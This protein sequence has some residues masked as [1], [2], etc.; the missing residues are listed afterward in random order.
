[1]I[2]TNRSWRRA[3]PFEL[4][5]IFAI[6]HTSALARSLEDAASRRRSI[7]AGLACE[8]H[9]ARALAITLACTLGTSR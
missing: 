2:G 9:G 6:G 4:T 5:F 8:R 7:A 3:K 1:M